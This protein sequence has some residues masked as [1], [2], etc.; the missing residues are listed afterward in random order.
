VITC[1]Y[2]GVLYRITVYR[3]TL[4]VLFRRFI[5]AV[6]FSTYSWRG[7]VLPCVI[8][9]EI[10]AVITGVHTT[11]NTASR[12]DAFITVIVHLENKGVDKNQ[13]CIERCGGVLELQPG[14]LAAECDLL[15]FNSRVGNPSLGI[16]L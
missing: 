8:M 5:T 7:S 14:S 2:T 3:I 11:G 10:T 4:Y 15:A 13:G 9:C 12:M 16:S 6:L 1:T